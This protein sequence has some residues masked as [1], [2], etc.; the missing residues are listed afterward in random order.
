M[1]GAKDTPLPLDGVRVLDLSRLI[2]GAV[3]TSILGDAG[4]EVIK[5]EET[6]VGDYERQIHPFIGSMAARFLILN[7]NKKSL[8]VN[9]KEPEGREVFLKAVKSADVLVEGFR[10]GSMKRLGLDYEELARINPG[11]IFC[12]ISSFGHEGPYR[13]VVAHDINVI[14]MSG[15]LSVTGVKDGPP[16][17]PGFQIAD[18]IAGTNAALGI[19]IALLA[20]QKTGRGQFVDISLFDSIFAWLFDA[21]RHVVAGETV[22]GRGVGRLW[23][24]LPNYRVYRTKEGEHI[25]VGSL[26]RKFQRALLTELGRDDLIDESGETTTSQDRES[27][28]EAR[29]ALEKVFLTKT[30]DEWM[31]QLAPLN[32]CVGPVNTMEEALAH[33]QAKA[34]GMVVDV[35]H[36]VAGKISQIGSPLKLSAAPLDPNRIPAPQLGEHTVEIMEE[37]GFENEEI[38]DLLRRRIVREP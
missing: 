21:A 22:P 13:D 15:F 32:I 16:A 17:I 29:A 28:A 5:I 10:P 9:L 3:C 12:S 24:G 31:E 30:R 2:P 27:D 33:P 37:L 8:A 18:N 25:T 14:G 4:A 26:E 38:E 35:N 23:G 11:L 6:N 34:R 36:P 19:V 1:T 7:R 20:R